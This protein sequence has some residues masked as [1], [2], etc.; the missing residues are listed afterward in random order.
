[1]QAAAALEGFDLSSLRALV[2]EHNLDPGGVT[3]ALTKAELAAHILL[4]AQ[5][6]AERDEKMFDY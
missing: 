2:A 6:R 3:V 5:R 4:Q 1:M